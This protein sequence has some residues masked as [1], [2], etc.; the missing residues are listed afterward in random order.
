EIW[1]WPALDLAHQDQCLF[2]WYLNCFHHF[3]SILIT[4]FSCYLLKVAART[5]KTIIK[6]N[7]FK[8]VFGLGSILK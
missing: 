3:N 7:N 1:L 2:V 6:I 4:I 8:K 5:S